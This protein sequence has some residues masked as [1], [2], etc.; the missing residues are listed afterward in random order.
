VG[1]PEPLG[2]QL[3]LGALA[4]TGRPDQQHAHPGASFIGP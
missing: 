3:G 1:D 4:G 2:D